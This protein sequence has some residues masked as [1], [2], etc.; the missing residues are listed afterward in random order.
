MYFNLDREKKQRILNYYKKEALDSRKRKEAAKKLRIQEELNYLH[1]KEKEEL[2]T[3]KKINQE[4]TQKKKALMEEY[5]QMLQKTKNN[6][7]GFHYLKKSKDVIINN[8]GKSKE[9]SLQENNNTFNY[10]NNK[11]RNNNNFNNSEEDFNTLSQVEK[12]RQIIKPIDSMNKFLTDEQNQNEVNLF[13]LKRKNNKRNF[14]KN[15]LYSQH[16]ESDML[17]KNKYGTEDI[18]ILKQKKKNIL[19]D[20]PYR[21]KYKYNLNNS[22]LENNPI[23]NPQN[24]MRYN[25]YFKEFYQDN[26][27][28]G[29]NTE[30]NNDNKNKLTIERINNN[31]IL[32][33]SNIINSYNINSINNNRKNKNEKLY[34]NFSGILDNKDLP[35]DKNDFIDKYNSYIKDNTNNNYNNYNNKI[36]SNRSMSQKYFK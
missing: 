2:E 16:E 5:I 24:N 34:R 10:I 28:K 4:K 12:A 26:N 22:T 3:E 18:L 1:Q 13:F 19:A 11:S 15:L 8:W 14:Y 9:E 23:L 36:L 29:I 20:N 27:N 6:I 25:R 30:I 7:P 17:N 32:N 33:G 35:Q 31:M 21:R